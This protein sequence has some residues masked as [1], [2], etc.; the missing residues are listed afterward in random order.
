VPLLTRIYPNG[1]ADVNHFDRAG[2]MGFV[3]AELLD[4]GLLHDLET[5]WPGGL[6]SYRVR[7]SL[8]ADGSVARSPVSSTSGDDSV[9]R[10]VAAPFRAD[11]GLRML[12]GNLGRAAI[13]VS[14]VPEERWVIEAPCAIFHEQDEVKAAFDRGELERDCVVVV[15]FQGPQAIGMP[16]LH[17]L[18]PV[19]GVLQDRGFKIALVTDGRMSG[20]S[21]R[22][23]AAIHVTP[24]AQTGGALARLRDGDIVR[25]DARTGTLDALVDRAEFAARPPA[26]ADLTA[27]HFGLGRELFAS[28][29]AGAGGADTGACLFG[30]HA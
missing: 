18:T 23:P 1:R 15:R 19:L 25:V 30:D 10:G 20:A 28:F 2:G 8:T 9:L 21:G 6:N 16:E 17:K 26:T 5:V 13:K 7:A 14:A 4:A 12:D 11:G 22:V 29:R 27:H 24:E 3:I